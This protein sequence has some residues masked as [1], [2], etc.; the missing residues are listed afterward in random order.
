MRACGAASVVAFIALYGAVAVGAC[1]EAP[2][3]L[4]PPPASAA[5][6]VSASLPAPTPPA[7]V[8]I[9]DLPAKVAVASCSHVAVTVVSGAATALD[10]KLEVGDVLLANMRRE[11]IE[12]MGGGVVVTVV[13][14]SCTCPVKSP[15]PAKEI[16]RAS[17]TP[18]ITWAKGA[19]RARLQ[20]EQRCPF[21]LGRLEGTAAVAEHV[22][23]GSW[24][25]LAAIDAAGTL[26]VDG[27]DVRIGPRQVVYIPAGAR[28]AW[29]PDPG[30][31]LKAVQIYSPGGPEQR[32]RALA[33]AEADGGAAAKAAK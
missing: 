12:V 22:H 24:E 15:M 14:P 33:T 29:R 2:S 7:D 27:K 16:L 21:F 5:P 17:A 3:P 30:A 13:A 18:E 20:A 11:P 23:D 19:F 6:P 25:I 1:R 32:F 8:A 26:A 28:H 9:V 31:T 4:P 10:E